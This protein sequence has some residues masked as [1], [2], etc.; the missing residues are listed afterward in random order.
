[1]PPSP[2]TQE[3][4]HARSTHGTFADTAFFFFA[5]NWVFTRRRVSRLNQLHIRS[6]SCSFTILL[7][8][9]SCT[10][11]RARA[12]AVGCVCPCGHS[13]QDLNSSH[14]MLICM[15]TAAQSAEILSFGVHCAHFHCDKGNGTYAWRN[16][17]E[18]FFLWHGDAHGRAQEPTPGSTA[19]SGV[20][21]LSKKH[22]LVNRQNVAGSWARGARVRCRFTDRLQSET[23]SCKPPFFALTCFPHA[24]VLLM[25]YFLECWVL[26]RTI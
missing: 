5:Q 2:R 24:S 21:A 1:M 17:P 25:V 15:C 10:G 19:V 20:K 7:T 12:W 13:V 14:S 16:T 4:P 18:F 9:G 26:L 8:C 23:C 6:I 3:A 11:A 22:P